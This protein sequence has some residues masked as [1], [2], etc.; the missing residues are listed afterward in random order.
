MYEWNDKCLIF[1]SFRCSS[2]HGSSGEQWTQH[3]FELWRHNFGSRLRC[4]RPSVFAS[5][6]STSSSWTSVLSAAAGFVGLN[7]DAND[8]IELLELLVLGCW[9]NASTICWNLEEIQ[10]SVSFF[11]PKLFLFPTY[12]WRSSWKWFHKNHIAMLEFIVINC[13]WSARCQFILV[14]TFTIHSKIE[15]IQLKCIMNWFV[16]LS[17]RC[18]W[19]YLNSFRTFGTL[20]TK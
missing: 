4:K 11:L 5:I 12:R 20:N 1:C 7:D 2:F 18:S 17:N 13:L 16:E 6:I 15:I 3:P 14:V 8:E 19:E 10:W 9:P